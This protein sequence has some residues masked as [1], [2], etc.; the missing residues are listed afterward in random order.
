MTKDPSSSLYSV[1]SSESQQAESE[2]DDRKM[3]SVVGGLF[4]PLVGFLEF[5]YRYF[6]IVFFILLFN[7]R[8]MKWRLLFEKNDTVIQG[9]AQAFKKIDLRQSSFFS[10]RISPISN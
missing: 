5:L 2:L 6:G 9:A 3:A 4:S 10:Q 1:R 7:H 8:K